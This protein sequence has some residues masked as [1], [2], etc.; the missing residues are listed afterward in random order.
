MD[1][2]DAHHNYL[3]SCRDSITSGGNDA[4]HVRLPVKF[5]ASGACQYLFLGWGIKISVAKL[6]KILK[7]SATVAA[8]K[9]LRVASY[10]PQYSSGAGTVSMGNY[11]LYSRESVDELVALGVIN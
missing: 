4:S 3:K 8:Q 5:A 6:R 11:N 7:D 2:Y 1:K 10:G 9:E